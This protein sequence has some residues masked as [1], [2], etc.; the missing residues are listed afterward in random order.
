MVWLDEPG[1]GVDDVTGFCYCELLVTAN[2]LMLQGFLD[3]AIDNS[4]TIKIEAYK[5]DGTTLISD[6]TNSFTW[7]YATKSDGTPY[8]AAMLK[9]FPTILCGECFILHVVIANGNS[10]IFDQWTAIYCIASC[11]QIA[12]GTTIVDDTGNTI[13]YSSDPLPVVDNTTSGKCMRNVIRIEGIYDCEDNF[14]DNY[15][16][17]PGSITGGNSTGFVYRRITNLQATFFRSKREITKEISFNCHTQKVT[18][19]KT[20]ELQSFEVFPE[21]KVEELE[22][23]LCAPYIKIDGSYFL[24]TGG[25]DPFSVINPRNC[26]NRLY[27]FKA[28]LR[29]CSIWQI[30]GC[31][32]PCISKNTLFFGF[33]KQSNAY[34][35]ENTSLIGN[36]ITE[37]ENY[38]KAQNGTYNVTEQ[39]PILPYPYYKILKVESKGVI[40]SY[41]YDDHIGFDAR[42]YGKELDETNPDYNSLF[43]VSSCA[44]PVIGTITFI[45]QVC[46]T[47]GFRNYNLSGYNRNSR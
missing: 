10:R 19:T 35:N 18:S 42:V 5:T 41:I 1:I 24:Y 32:S 46:A 29:D 17:E 11:C 45:D 37:V 31:D 39:T 3:H 33:M 47:P 12:T 9:S 7:F 25:E 27:K 8:F 38:L 14:G 22:D 15:Y 44:I 6:I 26:N 16:G 43:N 34:Y 20:Y 23:M 21:W 28:T 40:P 13:P 36:T 30:F 4:W 2:D